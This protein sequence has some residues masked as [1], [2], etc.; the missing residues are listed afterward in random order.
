MDAPGSSILKITS[1][2]FII[3][4]A[5]S[6]LFSL[7]AVFGSSIVTAV[8][9]VVGVMG[10]VLLIGSII[11]IIVSVVELIVGLM[12]YKKS[13]DPS[14][15][16]FFIVIGIVLCILAL[17]SMILSFQVTG[18][19]SFALPVLYVVGGYMNK[20]AAVG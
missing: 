20:N 17:V 13:D 9:G 2:L 5:V 6:T 16:N 14:Q 15:A 10:G 12:G 11:L 7:L 19:I 8:G 1:I 4:G 18:L 3:F